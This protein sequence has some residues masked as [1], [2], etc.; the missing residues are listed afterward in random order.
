[1]T[2][3]INK[4]FLTSCSIGQWTQVG[5]IPRIK[6][7]SE[8]RGELNENVILLQGQ[9]VVGPSGRELVV[10]VAPAAVNRKLAIRQINGQLEGRTA[11]SNTSVED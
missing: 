1:M 8:T 4:M 2:T 7:P 10:S 11:K 6:G 5:E 3:S 9:Y